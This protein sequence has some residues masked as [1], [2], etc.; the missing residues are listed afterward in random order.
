M[1]VRFKSMSPLRISF[2]VSLAFVIGVVDTDAVRAGKEAALQWESKALAARRAISSMELQMSTVTTTAD[3]GPVECRREIW[4]S[5][6]KFREDATTPLGNIGT[7]G[8]GQ[9]YRTVRVL[10]PEMQVYWH[11]RLPTG[12]GM[13]VHVRDLSRVSANPLWAPIDVRCLG[14]YTTKMSQLARYRDDDILTNPQRNSFVVR[15]MEWQGQAGIEIAYQ[16]QQNPARIIVIP[17]LGDAVALLEIKWGAPDYS[18]VESTT[19]ARFQDQPELRFFPQQITYR[20]VESGKEQIDETS[21]IEVVSFN[22]PI[23]AQVFQLTGLG[24]PTGWGVVRD[25]PDS[26]IGADFWDGQAVVN[27]PVAHPPTRSSRT[28]LL[29]LS[30]LFGSLAAYALY[31]YLRGA[32]SNP[33]S[34]P[35]I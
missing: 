22:Q 12:G 13:A 14:L 28:L 11:D 15:E 33:A 3:S 23:D 10:T 16:A 29:I 18:N 26:K 8:D 27:S 34:H 20:R 30:A 32:A 31:R 7:V 2:A 17:G 35:R 1:T 21:T 24:I 19:V 25:P 4:L 9:N 6:N 5:G